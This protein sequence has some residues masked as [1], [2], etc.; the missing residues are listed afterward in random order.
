M[1]KINI[2]KC[3]LV[4]SVFFALL[5]KYWSIWGLMADSLKYVFLLVSI[6]FSLLSLFRKKYSKKA[7]RSILLF[8]LLS[9]VVC[10][11]TGE[12]DFIY[13]FLLATVFMDEEEGDYLF[14]KYYVLSGLILFLITILFGKL[15][16][17]KSYNA[18]RRVDGVTIQRSSLGF[19]HVNAVFKNYFPICLGLYMLF[20]NQKFSKRLLL[21]GIIVST[22]YVLYKSTNCRTG[23]IAVILIP[24]ADIIYSY[25]IKKR[26]F[27]IIKYFFIIFTIISVGIAF[28]FGRAN[29]EV[30]V[31]LSNRPILY[32][33]ML[34]KSNITL[35]GN[36][37]NVDNTYFWLLYHK[38]L[39]VY[40]LYLL[41]Y[42][43][44]VEK[45]SLNK[46][47]ILPI[48]LFGVYSMFENLDVYNYNFLFV[49]ELITIL[50]KNKTK[51]RWIDNENVER[52][53]CNEKK[54]ELCRYC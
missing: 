45:L 36:E 42:M 21:Y 46:I 44:S 32:Y 40:M 15:G 26:N 13:A 35:F 29:S 3:C 50:N 8:G 23:Y 47:F 11:I 9:V 20:Y 24:I 33:E 16:I 31:L 5:F 25:I 28:A 43:K 38:G 54:I 17:T 22:G 2:R 12:I 1:E 37:S 7:I 18:I 4:A 48:L 6:F 34:T 30:N 52:I 51:Y 14:I 10:Y 27:R 49:I 19:E 41:I 39:F 53:D